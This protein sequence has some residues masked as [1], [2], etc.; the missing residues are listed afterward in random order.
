[1]VRRRPGSLG[2]QMMTA[3]QGIFKPGTSRHQAKRNHRERA[4]ITSI[5]TMKCMAH[6][7]HQFGRFVRGNW[8]EVKVV[9]EIR[10]E[11]ALAYIALLKKRRLSGGGL[12]RA[13]ASLRKLDTACRKAHIFPPD[14]PMLLPYKNQGGPEGFHSKPK[15]VPYTPEQAQA[16]IDGI[17]GRYPDI[18][19]LLNVMWCIGLRVTEAAYLRAQDIDLEKMEVR[20]NQADNANR[21]KGGRPRAIQYSLEHH[22][23]MI[24]LKNSPENQP[25]GHLFANRRG[26]PDKAQRNVRKTC[27]LLG[28]TCLGTHAFRK[29]FSVAQYRQ[30]REDG[31]SDQEALLR[32]SHQ[33]GHNRIDVT[34]QSYIPLQ[35]RKPFKKTPTR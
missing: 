26:L 4:L 24:D 10:P 16:I 30:A 2:Y 6:D 15:P 19:R 25:T 34:R 23:F 33:L 18:A 22:D 17:A 11:M 7:V 21:T 1:M 35:E 32:T 14:A 8:P 28:I 12:G 3:L 13:A 27:H 31:A 5:G 9:A 20:L 29:T